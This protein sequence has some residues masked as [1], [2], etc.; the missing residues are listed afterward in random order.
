[1]THGHMFLFGGSRANN[2]GAK[3]NSVT[4]LIVAG[5]KPSLHV[6]EKLP[7]TFCVGLKKRKWDAG[8]MLARLRFALSKKEGPNLKKH[9]NASKRRLLFAI[10]GY[11]STC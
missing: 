5:F 3:G 8:F 1:M 6:L 2:L 9:S 4:S 11:V 10:R 7:Q